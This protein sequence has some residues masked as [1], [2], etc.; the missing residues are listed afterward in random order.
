MLLGLQ[1][2]IDYFKI[3]DAKLIDITDSWAR[4]YDVSPEHMEKALERI[5]ANAEKET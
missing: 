4:R 1:E 3:L 5:I 2:A